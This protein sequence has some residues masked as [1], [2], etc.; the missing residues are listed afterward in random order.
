MA[1]KPSMMAST[2]VL[3]IALASAVSAAPEEG[4]MP[5]EVEAP[6]P[7]PAAQAATEEVLKSQKK[8]LTGDQG[9]EMPS[10]VKAPV[11]DPE[12]QAE[13]GEML[14][15]MEKGLQGR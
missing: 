5:K 14:K 11:P 7:D 2:A 1:Y 8:G 13:T 4:L 3:A 12:A 9:G 15:G 6:V 10:E